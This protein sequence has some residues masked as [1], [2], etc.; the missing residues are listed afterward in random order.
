[1]KKILFIS[2]FRD[3]N[4]QSPEAWNYSS[5]MSQ[6]RSTGLF[7]SVMFIIKMFQ[8]N[9]R[10]KVKFVQVVDNSGIDKE[11]FEYKPD[12]VIIEALWVVP[13]KFLE[14]K[15]L[16]PKVKWIIRLHSETP[17]L[18]FEG[19][20]TSWIKDYLNNGVHLAANSKRLHHELSSVY[21][22]KIYFLPN[23][24]INEEE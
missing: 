10:A 22:T 12:I 18:S 16:H 4:Y 23:Y 5:E 15:G 19:I 2:K 24:Y 13:E 17:F 7:N 11:V 3:A 1:M 14:L 6:T 8:K 21:K 9:K 20:A